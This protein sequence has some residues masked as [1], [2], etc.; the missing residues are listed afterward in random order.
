MILV[1]YAMEIECE[2]FLKKL[3]HEE[4]PPIAPGFPFR[5]FRAQLPSG[6]ALVVAVA[7]KE[8]PHGVDAIGTVPAAVLAQAAI[9]KFRPRILVN[10]GT[11]GG[12]ESQGAKI[13]EVY[14]GER[15]VAYH[16]RRVQI[17][18]F[19]ENARGLYPVHD[20]AEIARRL[21]LKTGIVSSGD[22]LDCAPEDADLLRK[23]EANLKEME[24]A[25]IA[26]VCRANQVP[27]V[28]L[29]AVTDFVD[30]PAPTHDQF[31][32]NYGVAVEALS[33]QLL[34]V[35]ECLGPG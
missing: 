17:P 28:P 33:E 29:K 31:F 12:W 9:Q 21:G 23:N 32:A 22:A 8:A 2:P 6:K 35:L 15:H 7:G 11:A 3:A 30:H 19:D 25:A 16:S 24:A 14:L 5:V 13:G 20:T 18:G 26:W 1:Q 10:A 27:F 34:R 4:L